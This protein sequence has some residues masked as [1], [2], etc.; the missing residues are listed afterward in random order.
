[1]GLFEEAGRRFEQFKQKATAVADEEAD[2]ECYAC[3]ERFH[4]EGDVCPECGSEAVAPVM[5]DD[6]EGDADGTDAEE[7]N[8]GEADTDA[9]ADGDPDDAAAP[10]GS[11][12]DAA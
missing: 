9:E 10:T 12:E 5:D 6:D 4:A 11:D 1:M 8:T 2:Y 3:G 7:T